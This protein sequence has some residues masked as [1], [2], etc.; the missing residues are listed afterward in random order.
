MN[1]MLYSVFGFQ[2]VLITTYASLSL[3]WD[4]N[5]ADT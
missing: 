5:N 1:Y 3:W 4:H 2:F